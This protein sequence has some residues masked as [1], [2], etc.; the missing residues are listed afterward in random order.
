MKPL[1]YYILYFYSNRRIL[2]K[3]TSK[4]INDFWNFQITAMWWITTGTVAIY[5]FFL[6]GGLA[7]SIM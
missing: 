4:N 7:Y 5:T 3:K 6:A 1:Y 2:S